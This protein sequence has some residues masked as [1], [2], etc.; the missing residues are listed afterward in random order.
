MWKLHRFSLQESKL[1]ALIEN[2][3][4]TL[5]EIQQVSLI[6][7]KWVKNLSRSVA[8]L[9]GYFANFR[10]S[11]NWR[12]SFSNSR[13]RGCIV[14]EDWRHPIKD[15]NFPVL[16]WNARSVRLKKFEFFSYI[17]CKSVCCCCLWNLF[18]WEWFFLSPLF[19]YLPARSW[20]RNSRGLGSRSLVKRGN[21]WVSALSPNKGDGGI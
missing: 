8:K 4:R 20:I 13:L 2:I 15:W 16:F 19:Y 1:F 5:G 11:W 17:I 12:Q 3:P 9:W 21:A 18:G 10:G 14:L 7:Q 6:F